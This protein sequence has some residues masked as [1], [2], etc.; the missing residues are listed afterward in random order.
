MS[1]FDASSTSLSSSVSANT[2]A[3]SVNNIFPTFGFKLFVDGANHKLW[4]YIFLDIC[5]SAKIFNQIAGKFLPT[6][7]DD[8][9]WYSIDPKIKTWIYNTVEPNLLQIITGE[10]LTTKDVCDNIEQ[11]FVTNKVSRSL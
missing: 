1:S 7:D 9:D 4:R 11:F 6:D 5:H 2:I 10:N 3:Y 8:E